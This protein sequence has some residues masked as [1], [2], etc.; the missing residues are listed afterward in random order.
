VLKKRIF[1]KEKLMKKE[2]QEVPVVH[3]DKYLEKWDLPQTQR[4][5]G[6]WSLS[7]KQLLIDSLFNMYDIPKFYVRKTGD[8]ESGLIIDGQQR[9]STILSFLNNEFRLSSDSTIP[10]RIHNK[11]HR[12][13]SIKDQRRIEDRVLDVVLVTCTEDQE[14]GLFLRLNNG[15]PLNT[16][17]KRNAI[18]GPVRDLVI[19]LSEH[20]FFHEKVNRNN[21]R[22]QLHDLA[23]QLLILYRN[24][25]AA[26]LK[27]RSLNE[28]YQNKYTPFSTVE[29]N[30]AKTDITKLL[31][32]LD[33]IFKDTGKQLK[34]SNTISFFLLLR[35]LSESH[36]QKQLKDEL[37]LEFFTEFEESRI[38]NTS[39]SSSDENF[40]EDLD[41]YTRCLNDSPDSITHVEQRHF[42]LA[43]FFYKKFNLPIVD[44]Q[45]YFTL[46]QRYF[47]WLRDGKICTSEECKVKAE[48]LPFK[49]SQAD[50]KKEWCDG[51]PTSLENGQTL[52]IPCHRAKTSAFNSNRDKL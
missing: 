50:H 15:S 26:D 40:N 18:K 32:K 27:A 21:S 51:H 11:T 5:D 30:R 28:L 29:L 41:E 23:A 36:S 24:K 43:S 35:D 42:I 37:L 6:V 17:E 13:L 48:F 8:N 31:T 49:E 3:L 25:G 45:R 16:A 47:M 44:G 10:D 33:R 34:K 38:I 1:L 12:E 22:Y 46:A 2:K 19:E 39:V 4:N 7:Q 52:C 14:E 9:I 20:K